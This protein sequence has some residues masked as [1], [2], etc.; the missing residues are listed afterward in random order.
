MI[1]EYMEFTIMQALI[2][3]F[4]EA[5]LAQ[6]VERPA[7]KAGPYDYVNRAAMG[8][9]PIVGVSFCFFL[10]R[11]TWLHSS[12]YLSLFLVELHALFRVLHHH[13]FLVLMRMI[14]TFRIVHSEY[15][16]V[17]ELVGNTKSAQTDIENRKSYL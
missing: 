2:F 10:S 13:V 9:S 16:G 14:P 7:F 15:Y 8:S 5:H 6:S 11:K 17:L 1:L 3:T 12:L 4:N